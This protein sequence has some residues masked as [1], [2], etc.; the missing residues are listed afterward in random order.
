MVMTIPASLHPA[1]IDLAA[2]LPSAARRSV[3]YS[4]TSKPDT[5]W[6]ALIR[7]W[8]IGSP[9]LPSPI[10]PILAIVP[11]IPVLAGSRRLLARRQQCKREIGAE[12]RNFYYN[13]PHVAAVDLGEQD[14]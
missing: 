11:P 9:I 12:Q 1:A 13:D 14:L 6:P 8:A 4:L 7:F 3:E 5:A 2:V 10:K